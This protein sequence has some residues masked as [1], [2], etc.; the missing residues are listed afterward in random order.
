MSITTGSV[1][2]VPR[3]RWSV[4][5]TGD[6]EFQLIAPVTRTEGGTAAE[7]GAFKANANSALP[8]TDSWTE[9]VQQI[10]SFLQE[11]IGIKLNF[12]T[13]TDGSTVVQVLNSDTGQVIGWIGPEKIAL[14]R[15]KVEEVRG[16][17]FDGK[18]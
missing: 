11:D 7:V 1:Q 15:D 8:V 14:F 16:I 3:G 9:V 18:A 4:Q 2:R 13:D 12:V 5:E 6:R 17:L 10:Q